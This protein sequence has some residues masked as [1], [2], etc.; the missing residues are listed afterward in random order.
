MV[1][2]FGGV[3]R[4]VSTLA[5]YRS[6]FQRAIKAEGSFHQMNFHPSM[7]YCGKQKKV[8][9]QHYY[10]LVD[11]QLFIHVNYVFSQHFNLKYF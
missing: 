5:Q 7:Y 11:L 3:P 2:G 6:K 8:K 10:I 1:S 4:A 9:I